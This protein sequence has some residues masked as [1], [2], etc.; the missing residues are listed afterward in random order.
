MST[1]KWYLD[2]IIWL[3][4]CKI[5]LATTYSVGTWSRDIS[6]KNMSNNRQMDE[7]EKEL[8]RS[9]RIKLAQPRSGW[10]HDLSNIGRSC[11]NNGVKFN[12]KKNLMD[13]PS[14]RGRK[15]LGITN[16]KRTIQGEVKALSRINFMFIMYVVCYDSSSLHRAYFEVQFDWHND[17]SDY[18]L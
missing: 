12:S 3:H 7:S 5:N 1:T 15:K 9:S 10:P 17:L 2:K 14:K 18:N 8:S 6:G 13:R 16:W 4:I 11:G